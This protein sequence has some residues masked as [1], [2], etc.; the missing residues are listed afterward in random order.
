MTPFKILCDPGYASDMINKTILE[1]GTLG[2]RYY[3]NKRV[4]VDRQFEKCFIDINNEKY[5]VNLKIS[6]IHLQDRIKIV[7]IKP[8]FEDLKRISIRSDLTI[9][10]VLTYCQPEIEKRYRNKTK[11]VIV[12]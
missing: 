7:N 2:V 1:L 6:F 11:Q 12:K 8:E 9:K 10:E 5:E 3:T 4:C